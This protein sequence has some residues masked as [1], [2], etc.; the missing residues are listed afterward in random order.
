MDACVNVTLHVCN[1][2]VYRLQSQFATVFKDGIAK[3]QKLQVS[4]HLASLDIFK[5]YRPFFAGCEQDT[6]LA[7]FDVS[8]LDLHCSKGLVPLPFDS[9]I[10]A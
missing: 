7:V 6:A 4:E 8:Q 9:K 3:A 10:V 2:H 1:L 5:S